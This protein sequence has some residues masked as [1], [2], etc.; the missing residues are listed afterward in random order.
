MFTKIT[1]QIFTVPLKTTSKLM[2]SLQLDVILY[3]NPLEYITEVKIRTLKVILGY[4]L[5]NNP[6]ILF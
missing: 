4:I 6:H 3:N 5:L 2:K 1:T